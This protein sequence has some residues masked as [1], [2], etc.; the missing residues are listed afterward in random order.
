M[1]KSFRNSFVAGLLLLAPL[2]V[3]LLVVNFL[4][5]RV[6][7]PISRYILQ[8]I[9][10]WRIF[11]YELVQQAIPVL[12]IFVVIL[13]VTFL[14]SLS[15]Y[16]LG[17]ML[18][19]AMERII[20]RVPFLNTVYNT[21][22]QIVDTFSKQNKA[23]FQKAVLIE[24]PRKGIW[25]VGFLTGDTRGEAQMRTSKELL[26]IFVPTTPNPTSGFLLLVPKD[27]VIELQMS[28]GDGMKLIIS[29]GAVVPPYETNEHGEPVLPITINNPQG[30]SIKNLET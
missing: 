1:L 2:G 9:P 18:I 10:E 12:A 28:I 3:T 24:Y 17:K 5:E 19:R 4:I 25:A 22:K 16:F 20:D 30:N 6:G 14:G 27:E 26:N 29:G 23:V 15:N 13:L 11:E 7:R 8:F 21:V